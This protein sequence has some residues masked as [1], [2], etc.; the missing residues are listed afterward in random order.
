MHFSS[1]CLE[2][3]VYTLHVATLKLDIPP[4]I[5]ALLSN[6]GPSCLGE[7]VNYTCTVKAPSHTWLIGSQSIVVNID[8]TESTSDPYTVTV[9]AVEGSFITSTLSVTS[10]AELNGT[11]IRCMDTSVLPGQG[12]VQEITARVH[13]MTL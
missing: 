8:T 5:S 11:V 2:V 10:F 13:G 1:A 3:R 9:V 6:Q 7:T 12:E 4:G